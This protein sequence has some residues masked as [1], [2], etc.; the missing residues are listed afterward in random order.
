[1]SSDRGNRGAVIVKYGNQEEQLLEN[2]GE[3]AAD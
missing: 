3:I 2:N 1:M